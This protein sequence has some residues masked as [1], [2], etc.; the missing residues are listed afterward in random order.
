MRI[1]FLNPWTQASENQVYHSQAIAADR[2]GH[3]LIH[4]ANS[5]DVESIEPDFVLAVASTQPKLSKFTTYGVIHEPRERF[6]SSRSYY[7]NLLSYDG[8][9]TVSETLNK[10][11]KDINFATGKHYLDVG[12]YYVTPQRQDITSDL[13]Y[14]ISHHALTLT[15]LGTNWDKRRQSFFRRLSGRDDVQIFGPKQSWSHIESRAYGGVLPFDGNS[16]QEVYR[17]HGLGLCF[18]SRDHLAD[19]IISNRLFEITSVGSI[20]ICCDT[21]WIRKWFGDS[22]YYVNQNLADGPLLEQVGMRIE[23]IYADPATAVEKGRTAKAIFDS[24]FAAEKLIN[25]A[26]DYHVEMQAKRRRIV[27]SAKPAPLI[28][29]IIRCGSRPI[30]V[31]RRAISSIARQT[32]GRFELLFVRW[33]DIDLTEFEASVSE[34][35]DRITVIDCFGQSRSATLW[36]GLSRISGD[37]FSVLDDDDWLFDTH[38]ESLFLA[39]QT[40][41]PERFF[42]FS[43]AIREHGCAKEVEAGATDTR[44]LFY[45]GAALGPGLNSIGFMSNSFVASRDLLNPALL[46]DPK[47][48]TAEDSYLILSLLAQVDPTFSFSA[49]S[50]H[51]RS[52][53]D[54]AFVA[55]GAERF[56]DLM[57]LQV[58]LSGRYRPA[59]AAKDAWKAMSDAWRERGSLLSMGTAPELLEKPDRIVVRMMDA[60]QSNISA[61]LE[62]VACGY[63]VDQSG[64][65]GR[66]APIEGSIG[67]AVV[68]PPDGVP[69]AFG[70]ALAVTGPRD[71]K[72]TNELVLVVDLMVERG[73]VGLGL[74][75]KDERDFLYRRSFRANKKIWEVHI[76]VPDVREIGRLVVQNWEDPDGALAKVLGVKFLG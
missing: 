18:L 68:Q 39:A 63:N 4:C 22:V 1:A 51:D 26:V 3:E 44:E 53:H 37:F 64:F 9:L 24:T 8:Y 45:F 69:W 54:H 40:P 21:P 19:D 30:E 50:V 17:R 59:F 74:L 27:A 55:G 25:N 16:V 49:T 41:L 58:R 61:E 34:P 5:S 23:E 46:E 32:Y 66:S 42:A 73:E 70:V 14:L 20:A 52:G 48:T 65:S 11:L 13:Q 12:F 60:A 33:Q 43:G 47:M 36:Q 29:V 62:E 72:F 31:L 38:F 35:I 10:F 2:V 15:Y 6:L 75:S 57:T 67:S 76:H 28:S 56:E 71:E 7:N